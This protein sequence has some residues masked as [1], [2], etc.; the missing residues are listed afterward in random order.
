LPAP[1][2]IRIGVLPIERE[3]QIDSAK[4]LSQVLLVLLTD[5]G[6]MSA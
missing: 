6:Q 3:G 4:S 1:F 5:F 2:A